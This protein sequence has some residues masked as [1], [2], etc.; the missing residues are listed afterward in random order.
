MALNVLPRAAVALHRAADEA[1]AGLPSSQQVPESV[2]EAI[3]KYV[4][5]SESFQPADAKYLTN[6]RG[7]LMFVREE[8]RPFIT[9]ELIRKTTFT[10]I[11][12]DIEA[13]IGELRD[14]GYTQFTIQ[15]VPGQEEAI[16]DWA[17]LKKNFA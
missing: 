11:A 12:K 15:I 5:L 4:K 8:E 1:I 2:S 17:C 9:E 6:H 13:R 10:G 3:N 16:E 14:A 7:H